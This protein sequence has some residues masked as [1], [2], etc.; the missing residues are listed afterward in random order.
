MDGDNQPTGWFE[1]HVIDSLSR[2]ELKL[3]ELNNQLTDT[4]I[5]LAQ[6]K[7]KTGILAGLISMLV[8]AITGYFLKP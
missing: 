8:A 5:D 3:I 7:A 4:R 1:R 6:H 2:Q